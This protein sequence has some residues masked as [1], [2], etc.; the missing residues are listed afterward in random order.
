MP[1]IA[2]RHDYK[3]PREEA[4]RRL[5]ELLQRF[6]EKYRFSSSAESE[7]RMM[8]KGRGAKGYVTLYETQIEFE[9]KLPFFLAPLHSRIEKGIRWEVTQALAPR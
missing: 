3:L 2:F 7:D 9:L 8:I 5:G 1:T 6:A 4:R